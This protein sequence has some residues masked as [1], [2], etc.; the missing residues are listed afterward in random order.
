MPIITDEWNTSNNIEAEGFVPRRKK[1]SATFDTAPTPDR[2]PDEDDGDEQGQEQAGDLPMTETQFMYLMKSAYAQGTAYQTSILQ[3]R[4]ASAYN[5]WNN[6]HN[7]DS[8][9]NQT[10]FRGRTKLFRPK[11]RATARK[12]AAD[13]AAALFST[14]EVVIVAPQNPRDKEQAA[15]AAVN[16]ELINYRMDRSSETAGIPWFMISMGAHMTAQLT[17]LCISKQYWEYKT[18]EVEEEVEE[19]VTLPIGPGGAMVK[20]GTTT[21]T[22]TRRKIVRD[23]PRIHLLPPEDVIRD[24]SASWEDQAQDSSYIILRFPMSVSEA[25]AFVENSN[26]RSVV[27]FH[28]LSP[29]DLSGA[30]GTGR[31]DSTGS[32]ATRRARENSG[33]DR[34]EDNSVD[35]EYQTVWLH[36]NF[37]RIEGTDYVFWTIGTNKLISNIVKVEDA[38]PER[39]GARPIVI[40]Y[41]SLEPFKIDPM[42]PIESW[43]PLQAEINDIVNLR[44][45]SVKQT[46]S[47]LA[48]VRRGK[49]VDIRA[50]QNRSPDSVAYVQDKD[51]LTFDRP[52][53][54]GQSAYVEMERLNADFDDQAGNFSI[55]SVQSNRQLGDTVGGMKMMGATANAMGEFDLRIWI[56]TWVEPVLRSVVALEQYYESDETIIALAADKAKLMQR[57]GVSKVTDELLSKQLT[58][59][60]NIGL[61]ASDPML[62][63]DKFAKATQ[64]VGGIVGEAIQTRINQDAVINEVFGKAGYKDAA[65][66]FFKPEGQ[67]DPRIKEA[68]QVIQKMQQANDEAEAALK[69]KSAEREADKEIA[70]MKI[71]GDIIKQMMSQQAQ[72][73]QVDPVTGMMLPPP[74]PMTP[75]IEAMLAQLLDMSGQKND[76]VMQAIQQSNQMMAQA[77]GQLVQ[78]MQQGFAQV[79][80]QTASTAAGVERTAQAQMASINRMLEVL[81]APK[82]IVRG[83]DGF[84]S[85]VVVDQPSPMGF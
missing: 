5:A 34:L 45:D 6:K 1:A 23:R 54:V 2:M 26:P 9:Y 72:P 20:L 74:P 80:G 25:R 39:H 63:L 66:R 35:A 70:K 52:G 13:A 36:E 69:E 73:P 21:K 17:G 29:A 71:F 49:S 43:Q 83:A 22:M 85:H 58:L 76:Q 8:K 48:I 11:T 53:D 77:L 28:E 33:N 50:I 59:T 75:Q 82:K 79:Q 16:H 68:Q 60:V 84:A 55:G 51:D 56:E 30:S 62:G 18:I 3:P 24:P 19:D 40:G 42:S 44:L 14:A 15:S 10:R 31:G 7:A 67:D 65:E 12:K 47:P 81:S 78:F 64:V 37:L 32:S 46:I 38:Y 41:A 57:F 27:Q 4:W 61:G